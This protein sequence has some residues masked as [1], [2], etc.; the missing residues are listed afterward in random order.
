[1][2]K[3]DMCLILLACIGMGCSCPHR[4]QNTLGSID[5]QRLK[6]QDDIKLV[7]RENKFDRINGKRVVYSGNEGSSIDE[8]I[9]IRN[10][11]NSMAGVKAEH[12][13]LAYKFGERG[14]DWD[15]HQQMLIKKEGRVY[16]QIDILL[17]DGEKKSVFFEV[18][19]FHKRK[20]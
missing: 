12:D 17:V 1:M 15:F 14:E 3:M 18:T 6:V 7:P 9:V 20:W 11:V 4:G 10:A 13:Y 2:K 5:L 8:A 19:S 16:D